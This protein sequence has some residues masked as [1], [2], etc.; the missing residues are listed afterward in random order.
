MSLII[1]ISP[2]YSILRFAR[3][4]YNILIFFKKKSFRYEITIADLT[5]RIQT[6]EEAKENDTSASKITAE[7]L[8][9]TLKDLRRKLEE[10]ESA[11]ENLQ[12]YINHLKS[13][14]QSVFGNE[15]SNTDNEISPNSQPPSASQDTQ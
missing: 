10:S 14:Y 5:N 6:L 3:Y 2:L 4:H 7:E 8:E 9:A 1:Q 11:K 12:S 13:S 15:N